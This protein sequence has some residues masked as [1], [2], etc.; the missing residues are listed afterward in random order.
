MSTNLQVQ[1]GGYAQEG[2]GCCSL[3]L[4]LF[5]SPR[6]SQLDFKK[7]ALLAAA[8]ITSWVGGD[9]GWAQF[10]RERSRR[11]GGGGG[12]CNNKQIEVSSCG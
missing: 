5:L 8:Q 9:G 10:G 11:G 12:F 6:S 2:P 1:T 7:H 3:M 4:S